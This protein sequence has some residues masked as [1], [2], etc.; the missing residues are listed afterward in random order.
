[1]GKQAKD[2]LGRNSPL[3]LLLN[4]RVAILANERLHSSGNKTKTAPVVVLNNLLLISS[5]RAEAH[6]QDLIAHI[7]GPQRSSVL[8]AYKHAAA[9]EVVADLVKVAGQSARSSSRL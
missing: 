8:I 1:M 5:I 7:H 9:R 6:L 3:A 2:T 4:A